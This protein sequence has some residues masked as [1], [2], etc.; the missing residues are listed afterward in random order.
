MTRLPFAVKE[1]LEQQRIRQEKSIAERLLKDSEERFR[2]LYNDALVGLYRTNSKGEIMLANKALINM[3]GFSSF[4][5]LA[6]IN[7]NKSGIGITQERKKFIERIEK[8]GEIIDLEAVWVCRDGREINVR[9]NAKLIRDSDGKILCYDG[10]V[11][12]ITEKRKAEKELISSLSIL[13]AS[14]DSTA[15]GILIVDGK[16]GIIKWNRKFS[17]MWKLPDNVL[18]THDDNAAINHILNELTDPENFLSIIKELYLDPEKSSF[19][20][21]E[22]KDGRV[23]D[24]Y[25]QP[26]RINQKVVGRVWSFRDVTENVRNQLELHK[27]SR[28]VEQNPASIVITDTNGIIEYVN[29]KMIEVTGYSKEELTGKN[30][31][32]LSS[33]ETSKDDYKV[34]WNTIKSGKEW[35]GEFHNRK[36]NGELYWESASVS[37][38]KNEKNEITH[39]LGIK[40][41][42]TLRKILEAKTFAGEQRYRELF[43]SNPVPTYVFDTE[44][45]VFIEVNDATVLNYGYSKEEF[46]GMTLMDIRLPEDIPDLYDSVKDLGTHVFYSANMR[47]RK[48][49]GTVFPVEITSHALPEKNGRK[50]RLVMTTDITERIK[51][52]EQMK[53]AKEKAE[54]SDNLKTLFLNNISHEVRTPLNGILGFAEIITQ[55]DL[56]EEDKTESLSM[57][58]ESSERLLNTITNYMD[59]SLLTSGNLSVH[60]RDFSPGQV[61]RGVFDYYKDLCDKKK[62]ELFLEIQDE[63]SGLFVKS[64]PEIF[65]KICCHLLN[66][67]V[68][69]TEKGSIHYGLHIRGGDLEIYVKDTGIGIGNESLLIVFER[70]VK[71]DHGPI[72]LTEGS[73]LGLSIAKGMT[74]LLGGNIRVESVQA[75]GSEIFFTIPLEKNAGTGLSVPGEARP[76]KI[77]GKVKILI[78]EDDETNYFYLNA[79]LTRE[80]SADIIHAHNGREAIELYT[81]NPDIQLILMDIKMPV[82]DGLEATRQIKL[83]NKDIPVIA[84]TA[85]AMSGDEERVLSSGCNGYLS[86]PI[87]KK[88]LLEKIAEF[89]T[90]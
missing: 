70:F 87:S 7:L 40:E 65:K 61:L 72:K 60:K 9:E 4:E 47:H 31:G 36:K 17:D 29:P 11:E 41:D 82:I 90:I 13:N 30:P 32:I 51:A 37:P 12:D 20:K 55:P 86:K 38:I 81:S 58:H 45:L 26:Q 88:A 76:D 25:S 3:L 44:S 2:T 59:I 28:A 49:D 89:I 24:R 57:L 73:G 5:E 66:N 8:E 46:A 80:T 6:A 39:F 23:F 64:D 19:D 21:L 71:E 1:A 75:V 84:I 42:I 15:D 67:A 16:G 83:L 50:T 79:L 69:F 63:L 53:L 48:K 52:A 22:F 14:L 10:T 18:N 34:L 35:K 78:A 85:Y 56:S 33:G 62:I 68:K 74:E 77:K 27:L 54:A 43:L